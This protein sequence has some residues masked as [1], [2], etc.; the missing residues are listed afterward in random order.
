METVSK[1]LT[2]IFFF[3][4]ILGLF[5]TSFSQTEDLSDEILVYILPDSLELP[6]KT[7]EVTDTK[8]L[9]IKSKSLDKAFK[10]IELKLIKKAFPEFSNEDTVKF[11]STGEKIKLPNMSRIFRLKLKK[12]K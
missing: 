9:K 11:S 2:F 3:I 12:K 10:K 4:L 5:Q 6:D 1:R 8:K 7:I